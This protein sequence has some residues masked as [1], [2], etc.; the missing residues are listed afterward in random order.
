MEHLVPS[1]PCQAFCIIPLHS[2]CLYVSNVF[3]LRIISLSQLT[4][5]LIFCQFFE[6]LY[7]CLLLHC[8]VSGTLVISEGDTITSLFQDKD[9]ATSTRCHMYML[10][11]SSIVI[12]E[13]VCAFF[14][15]LFLISLKS[16]CCTNSLQSSYFMHLVGLHLNLYFSWNERKNTCKKVWNVSRPNKIT[17]LPLWMALNVFQ[18]LTDGQACLRWINYCLLQK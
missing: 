2:W 14:L 15:L 9:P 4:L 10:Y 3:P 17:Y 6:F 11:L 16:L 5:L 8:L 7:I 12:S 13:S 18:H 1:F